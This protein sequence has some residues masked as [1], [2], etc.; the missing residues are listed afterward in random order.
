M[1]GEHF[2]LRLRSLRALALAGSLDP[3]DFE[4][5]R[6]II[7]DN[8]T[9]TF[10]SPA[11]PSVLKSNAEDEIYDS[12]LA[13]AVSANHLGHV[14]QQVR[15]GA[16]VN[17]RDPLTKDTM[18]MIAASRGSNQLVEWLVEQGAEVNARGSSG[19]TALHLCVANN[20]VVLAEYLIQIGADLSAVDDNGFTP[21]D[22]AQKWQTVRFLVAEAKYRKNHPAAAALTKPVCEDLAVQQR[23]KAGRTFKPA[24][25]FQQETEIRYPKPED[26][27]QPETL[28]PGTAEIMRIFMP[29]KSYKALL[30]DPSDSAAS[31]CK[32]FAQRFGQAFDSKY[33]QITEVARGS[34]R[35]LDSSTN[36]FRVRNNWPTILSDSSDQPHYFF[37]VSLTFDTPEDM[38]LKFRKFMYRN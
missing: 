17:S 32:R 16:S 20:F 18:L 14:K 8:A 25:Q 15:Q 34:R 6:R 7:I 21:R 23:P 37:E 11:S 38:K 22:L 3:K 10:Y 2:L 31:L 33:L 28:A 19:R 4:A 9:G 26:A 36:I 35:K 13:A 5:Q 29:N 1:F 12:S 24:T 30:V 27:T